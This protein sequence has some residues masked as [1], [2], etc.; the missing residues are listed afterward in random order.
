MTTFLGCTICRNALEDSG[1]D[2]KGTALTSSNFDDVASTPQYC[3]MCT[4]ENSWLLAHNCEKI[5]LYV[6]F[7][8]MIGTLIRGASPFFLSTLFQLL[9][10]ACPNLHVYVTHQ[11]GKFFR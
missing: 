2:E 3:G 10:Y 9:V 11:H 1:I 5:D 7:Y 8:G 4:L 6:I